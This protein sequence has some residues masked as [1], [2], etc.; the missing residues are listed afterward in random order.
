MYCHSIL[1]ASHTIKSFL[2]EGIL[3]VSVLP[4]QKVFTQIQM[5]KGVLVFEN[6]NIY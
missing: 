4:T 3:E 2:P 1:K 5:L 6:Q